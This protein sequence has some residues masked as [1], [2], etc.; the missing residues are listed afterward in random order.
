M[1]YDGFVD[2]IDTGDSPCGLRA[3]LCAL[4]YPGCGLNSAVHPGIAEWNPHSHGS[5]HVPVYCGHTDSLQ[6]AKSVPPAI[7]GLQQGVISILGNI[8]VRLCPLV[9]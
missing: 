7:I 5:T 6:T 3:K 2:R 4:L 8:R 1:A 9:V